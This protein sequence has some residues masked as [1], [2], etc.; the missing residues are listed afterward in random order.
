MN[1][2]DAISS[3]DR[4]TPASSARSTCRTVSQLSADE[5]KRRARIIEI[6]VWAHLPLLFGIAVFGPMGMRHG[7][8][9]LA[10]IAATAIGAHFAPTRS[11]RNA[12]LSIA[13]LGCSAGLIHLTG[14]LIEMHVHLYVG[15]VLIALLQ[16]WRP[17]AISVGFVL[18]HHIGLS[19][20]DPNSVFNH[21]AAQNKPILWALIHAALLIGETAAV[22]LLWASAHDAHART[23]AEQTARGRGGSGAGRACGRP[24]R[25]RRRERRVAVGPR[26]Q[27]VDDGERLHRLGERP[28]PTI[29]EITTTMRT[30]ADLAASA[31]GEAQ[32]TSQTM[33]TLDASMRTIDDVVEVIAGL[34]DQ[35]NLLALNATI[36]AARAGELGKGFA[37]VAG[38]VKGSASKSG[39]AAS[40]ISTMLAQIRR[41]TEAMLVRPATRRRAH[42]RGRLAAARGGHGDRAAVGHLEGAERAGGRL[43]RR[44]RVDRR[45]HPRP[46]LAPLSRTRCVS[47]HLRRGGWSAHPNVNLSL[48]VAGSTRLTFARG[49]WGMGA[50][51]G[52]ITVG[53]FDEHTIFSHGIAAVLADDPAVMAVTIDPLDAPTVDVAV[54]SLRMLRGSTS[55]ARSWCVYPSAARHVER[56]RTRCI[57]AAGARDRHARAAVRRRARSRSR[58]PDRGRCPAVPSSCSTCARAPILRMLADGAGTRGDLGAARLLRAHDQGCDPPRARSRWAPDRARRPFALAPAHISD[59]SLVVHRRRHGAIDVT[60]PGNATWITPPNEHTHVHVLVSAGAGPD[61]TVGEPGIHG[62]AVI[63]VHGIGVSTP[64]AATVAATTVGLPRLMHIE[65]D[66]M[67]TKG[68]LSRMFA[69]G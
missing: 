14:G 2:T 5:I 19:L 38:E 43:A 31:A 26:R 56:P 51:M 24:P 41:D 47:V 8:V 66:P 16:D 54:T 44:D 37:V 9:D 68:L 20:I 36:E 32:A 46:R 65:N 22:M 52:R 67:F 7:L 21:E 25:R 55:R 35:T 39:Q 49:R 50:R 62:A 40:D 27:R 64:N 15:M 1:Q 6:I 58:P 69:T 34:A 45:R 17:Y 23:E 12:M 10:P 18:V 57:R 33:D 61:S 29:D 11:M 48:S 42:R 13:L 3:T 28:R 59:L 63:G 53:V 60:C 30:V 4:P